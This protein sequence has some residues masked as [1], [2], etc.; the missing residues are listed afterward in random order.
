MI[1]NVQLEQKRSRIDFDECDVKFSVGLSKEEF[2]HLRTNLLEE[3]E[4]IKPYLHMLDRGAEVEQAILFTCDNEKYGLIVIPSETGYARYTA[5]VPDSTRMPEHLQ[6]SSLDEYDREMMRIVD[7]YA[8]QAV[9]NQSDGEYNLDLDEV[10]DDF[11]FREFNQNLFLDMLR[12]RP[13]FDD[14]SHSAGVYTAMIAKDYLSKDEYYRLYQVDIDI[15]EAKHIL[16]MHSAGGEQADF[17]GCKMD[18]IDFSSKNF[19]GAI[20]DDSIITNSMFENAIL[21]G[22]SFNQ[23]EINTCSFKNASAEEVKANDAAFIDCDFTQADFIESSFVGTRFDNCDFCCITMEI[24]CIRDTEFYRTR[25]DQEELDK[26]YTAR[27]ISEQ[28]EN[29]NL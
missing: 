18:G 29:M 24:S 28:N 26:C 23:A 17:R 12:E 6:Y 4:Y 22:S 2:Y 5:F 14:I 7:K 25:P 13:E 3:S 11:K 10:Y 1:Y 16:W 8:K 21:I 20:F 27:P 19:S 15:M 9:E